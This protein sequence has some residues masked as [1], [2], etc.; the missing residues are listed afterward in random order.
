MDN[1]SI[2]SIS[3]AYRTMQEGSDRKTKKFQKQLQKLDSMV[4]DVMLTV[5]EMEGLND[6]SGEQ[7]N[8]ETYKKYIRASDDFRKA[9]KEL[10][11]YLK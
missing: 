6:T 11:N 4:N 8:D 3:E 5:E 2:H 9:I 1:N 7:L 10:Q